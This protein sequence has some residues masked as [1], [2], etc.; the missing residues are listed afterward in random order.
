VAA[1]VLDVRT[2]KSPWK[3]GPA[4]YVPDE[5]GDLLGEEQ[6]RWFEHS[7][8]RSR[9]AVNVVVSGLQ[10]HGNRKH[11]YHGRTV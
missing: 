10:Y 8:R 7:I 9:A 6:W 4:S 2:N 11:N 3:K 1:F 5:D